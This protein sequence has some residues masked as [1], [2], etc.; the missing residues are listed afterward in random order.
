MKINEIIEILVNQLKN[1][2][3][4]ENSEVEYEYEE[5]GEKYFNIIIDGKNYVCK[6]NE[7]EGNIYWPKEF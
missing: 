7:E 3:G 2:F 5:N 1:N 6:V 4:F